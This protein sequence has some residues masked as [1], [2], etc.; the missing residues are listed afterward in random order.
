MPASV[1]VLTNTHAHTDSQILRC[2]NQSVRSWFPAKMRN[3]QTG[4]S[5]ITLSLLDGDGLSVKMLLGSLGPQLPPKKKKVWTMA[6]TYSSVFC[7]SPIEKENEIAEIF[8][9]RGEVQ[10]QVKALESEA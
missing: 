2:S 6:E 4:K 10:V 5:Q 8:T 9:K 7:Y 3:W 1:F